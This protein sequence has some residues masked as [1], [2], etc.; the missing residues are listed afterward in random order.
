MEKKS[1]LTLTP[2]DDGA[3]ALAMKRIQTD[4]VRATAERRKARRAAY[5]PI[6]IDALEHELSLGGRLLTWF[7]LPVETGY[8]RVGW[9]WL[10]H[11]LILANL[12][13]FALC[14]AA[15]APANSPFFNQV[16]VA[17]D[18][19]ALRWGLIP[20]EFIA[21][22]Q[23]EW[24]KLFSSMFMHGGPTHL[25]GN[26]WMLAIV[27]DDVERRLGRPAFLFV[28]LVGGIFADYCSMFFGTTAAQNGCTILARLFAAHSR[29]AAVNSN[30][31]PRNV[32]RIDC[33]GRL[34]QRDDGLAFF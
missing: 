18:E 9:A 34:V 20:S 32:N 21:N 33:N 13:C 14:F 5:R 17:V 31:V 7:G 26:L 27:G 28:Y 4:R 29:A 15:Y 23:T 6:H 1:N 30:A 25:L 24:I 11:S 8:S 10:T 19:G 16:L 22:P 12:V 3:L 2:R